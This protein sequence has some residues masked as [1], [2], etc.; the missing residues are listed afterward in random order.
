MSETGA[1]QSRAMIVTIWVLRV[2]L[3]ALFLAVGVL[4][5]VGIEMEVQVF[6]AVGLG[7]W[8]RYATGLA[9][10]VGGIMLL[11][12]SVSA[13][14]ALILLAVDIGA[15]WAQV[16][17]LH[18][19]WIHVVVIGALLLWLIYVQRQQILDRLRG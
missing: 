5:L 11:V 7:Q 4:K 13:F 2:V 12:P 17:I 14:G 3:A 18:Q 16:T 9:E 15:L 1:V 19:D 6:D 10:V 8:L